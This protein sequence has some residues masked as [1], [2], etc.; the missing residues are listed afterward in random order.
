[1]EISAKDHGPWWMDDFNLILLVRVCFLK[2]Y[3]FSYG[4]F[5]PDSNKIFTNLPLR[6]VYQAFDLTSSL[7]YL[8]LGCNLHLHLHFH[9]NMHERKIEVDLMIDPISLGC[10]FLQLNNYHSKVSKHRF[11]SD[12]RLLSWAY[13]HNEWQRSFWVPLHQE[14]HICKWLKLSFKSTYM[15]YFFQHSI[16]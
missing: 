1:M 11:H 15:H 8:V 2:M 9:F 6:I 16:F 5:C 14:I 12:H 10:L 4:L 3:F 13:C 7:L